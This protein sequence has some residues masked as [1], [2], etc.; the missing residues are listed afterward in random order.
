MITIPTKIGA[1]TND[2]IFSNEAHPLWGQVSKM[3]IAYYVLESEFKYYGEGM[4]IEIVL[5]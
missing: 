2:T 5:F 1:M 4:I 3:S